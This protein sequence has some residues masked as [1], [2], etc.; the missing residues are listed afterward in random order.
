[1]L[2]MSSCHWVAHSHV[3]VTGENAVVLESG[4]WCLTHEERCHV[5]IDIAL[6]GL[7]DGGIEGRELVIVDLVVGVLNGNLDGDVQV[8]A[9]VHGSNGKGQVD[10]ISAS[11]D[12]G[13]KESR[14]EEGASSSQHNLVSG[15][16]GTGVVVEYLGHGSAAEEGRRLKLGADGVDLWGS[17]ILGGG[18]ELEVDSQVGAAGVEEVSREHDSTGLRSR[19]GQLALLGGEEVLA[20]GLCLGETVTLVLGTDLERSILGDCGENL[21]HVEAIKR[22]SS[23]LNGGVVCGNSADAILNMSCV[24]GLVVA[25]PETHSGRELEMV[26]PD[27]LMLNCVV[28]GAESEL[29]GNNKVEWDGGHAKLHEWPRSVVGAGILADKVNACIGGACEEDLKGVKGNIALGVDDD[30]ACDL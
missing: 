20:D 28:A 4:G 8:D 19:G 23:T 25:L 18:L 11:A 13:V 16:M 26:I 9:G 15:R 10:N 3:F 17:N 7:C 5:D 29:M 21:D 24:G 6:L 2:V 22:C 30:I 14:R 1:M 12:T 27:A